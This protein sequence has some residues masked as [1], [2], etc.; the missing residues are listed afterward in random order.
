MECG[1]EA[2]AFSLFGWQ[3]DAAVIIPA[4]GC[5]RWAAKRKAADSRP[6]SKA[7]RACPNPSLPLMV[8]R[9]C[10]AEVEKCLLKKQPFTILRYE[11]QNLVNW[12]NQPRDVLQ[13]HMVNGL[14]Q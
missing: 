14:V 4:R 13:A 10:A 3:H 11:Q 7:L 2:S 6:Q 1:R 5:W 8:G 9:N 12:A